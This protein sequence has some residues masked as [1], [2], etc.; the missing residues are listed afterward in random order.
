MIIA[1]L[2]LPPLCAAL[3]L[4]GNFDNEKLHWLHRLTATGVGLLVAGI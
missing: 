2:C 1:L 4:K 3:A